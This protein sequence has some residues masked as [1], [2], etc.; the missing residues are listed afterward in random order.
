MKISD[1]FRRDFLAVHAKVNFYSQSCSLMFR[2]YRLISRWIG[3]RSVPTRNICLATADL[4]KDPYAKMSGK[5]ERPTWTQ[6]Q[7]NAPKL[8]VF[9]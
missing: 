3:V 6:P 1:L 4:K 8:K 9:F 2:G 5:R 7:D